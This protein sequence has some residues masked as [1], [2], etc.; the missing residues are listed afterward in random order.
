MSTETKKRP[1]ELHPRTR[2]DID[3]FVDNFKQLYGREPTLEE[4]SQLKYVRD[5]L[6]EENG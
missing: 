3:R 6:T 5:R 4:L 1:D 2:Q